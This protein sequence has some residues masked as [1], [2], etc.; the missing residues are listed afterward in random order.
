MNKWLVASLCCCSLLFASLFAGFVF[1]CYCMAWSWLS[2][3]SGRRIDVRRE[4]SDQIEDTQGNMRKSS[5]LYYLLMVV[6]ANDRIL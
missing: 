5:T 2:G 1:A 6:T 4:H 3:P